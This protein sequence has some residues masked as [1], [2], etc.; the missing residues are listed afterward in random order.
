MSISTAI[1]ST[2]TDGVLIRGYP[3]TELMAKVS[4]AEVVHLMLRGELPD[5]KTARLIDAILVSSVDHGPDAPSTHVARAA[6]SCGVPLAT[7]VAA[8]I[9]SIGTNHGGAGEACARLLQE[10]LSSAMDSNPDEVLRNAAVAIVERAAASGSH[11]PGFGHRV[12][13]EKDPRAETLFAFAQ[14]L[15][16]YGMHAR[17]ARLVAEELGKAKGKHLVLNIDGAQAALLSDLGFPWQ[18]VQPLFIIGRSLG[19]CAQAGEEIGS[20]VPLGY[21]KSAR[22]LAE[23]SGPCRRAAGFAPKEENRQ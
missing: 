19:L 18:Q 5:R 11:L 16:L 3:L 15:G 14:E 6:A 17:L 20:A 9:A 7:A 21:L 1:S 10:A 4:F 2:G 8:G 22:V 23:Y 12:Y 13:K